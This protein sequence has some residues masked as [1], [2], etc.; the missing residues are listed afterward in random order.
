MRARPVARAP[1]SAVMVNFLVTMRHVPAPAET[2]ALERMDMKI[3]ARVPGSSVRR[4][5]RVSRD[6]HSGYCRRTFAGPGL[7]ALRALVP[8]EGD[9][10]ERRQ[11][12]HVRLRHGPAGPARI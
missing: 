4:E 11:L 2:T 6:R 7:S 12:V 1:R 10:A 8:Q 3:A 9:P 5:E